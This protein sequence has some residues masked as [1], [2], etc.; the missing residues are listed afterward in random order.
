MTKYLIEVMHLKLFEKGICIAAYSID[1]IHGFELYKTLASAKFYIRILMK[2]D[3]KDTD[4]PG[5]ELDTLVNQIQEHKERVLRV[6][7]IYS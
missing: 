7:K 1:H 5:E 6:R 2:S 4:I 3:P